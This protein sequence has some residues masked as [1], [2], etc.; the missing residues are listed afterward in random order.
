MPPIRPIVFTN[1]PVLEVVTL[2]ANFELEVSLPPMAPQ[3]HDARYTTARFQP[4]TVID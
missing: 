1:A 4:A 2:E 3:G